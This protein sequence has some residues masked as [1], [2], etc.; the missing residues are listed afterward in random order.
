MVKFRVGILA[1]RRP[2]LRARCAPSGRRWHRPGRLAGSCSPQASARGCR[3]VPDLQEQRNAY[4]TWWETRLTAISDSWD[5]V[6]NVPIRAQERWL[7]GQI[8]VQSGVWKSD[9]KRFESA[10]KTK[11]ASIDP[12]KNPDHFKSAQKATAALEAAHAVVLELVLEEAERKRSWADWRRTTPGWQWTNE[13]RQAKVDATRHMASISDEQVAR[14]KCVF[15]GQLSSL[16][17]PS[18]TLSDPLCQLGCSLIVSGTVLSDFMTAERIVSAV[19]LF[20]FWEKAGLPEAVLCAVT[21][22]C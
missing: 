5:Q 11:A 6:Q 16:S 1:G 10:L 14:G 20:S 4:H 17:Q 7:C 12:A 21:R 9:W 2:G 3:N 19:S 13:Y 18:L 15:R 8:G 22:P